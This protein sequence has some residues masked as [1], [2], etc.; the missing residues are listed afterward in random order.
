MPHYSIMCI[1]TRSAPTSHLVS[2]FSRIA[3]S[4]SSSSALLTRI[5]HLGVRPLA[6]RMKAHQKWNF[7]GRY[8]R[9]ECIA[10]PA[11]LVDVERRLR[12][13]EEIV[14]F[15]TLKEKRTGS[16]L[17]AVR[18]GVEEDDD[19]DSEAGRAEGEKGEGEEEEAEESQSAAAI[20]AQPAFVEP[21]MLTALQSSSSI[22]LYTARLLLE[23]GVMTEED[24]MALDRH[25]PDQDWEE[26]TAAVKE[27]RKRAEAE[28]EQQRRRVEE[29]RETA[30]QQ[31]VEADFAAMKLYLDRRR[32][33]VMDA[34]A[35]REEWRA[36]EDVRAKERTRAIDERLLDKWAR[37]EVAEASKRRRRAGQPL[38]EEQ[39]TSIRQTAW[40]RLRAEL[41]K[42]QMMK[43]TPVKVLPVQ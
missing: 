26:R 9:L 20:T 27:E 41:K 39:Q 19:D 12:V 32:A 3:T 8:V 23:E 30:L 37:K 34:R 14:R 29:E 1:A 2:L 4:L 13:D 11:A 17:R 40:K 43:A 36:R 42:K 15:M 5:D 21:E 6:Y 24:I 28:A 18:V 33:E 10:S 7:H 38:T 25:R 22:D 16:K 35:V 31:R